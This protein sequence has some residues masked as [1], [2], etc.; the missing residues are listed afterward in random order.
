VNRL[1]CLIGLD[2]TDHIK[3]GC[4]TSSFD[5]LLKSIREQMECHIVE[6]RLVR[7]WPFANRRTRGNGALGAIIEISE[8]SSEKIEQ[9]CKEWFSNLLVQISN[10]PHSEVPASPCL[11][12]SFMPVPRDWYW[13]AVRK[14][15]DSDALLDEA[16]QNGVIVISS[17]STF[18]VVGACAA[19]SW[20]NISNSTWE[21]ISWRNDSRVGTPRQVSS[22]SVSELENKFPETFLNRDPTKGKSMIAP[23]TPCPV[24]YGIRG[25]SYSGVQKAHDWLQSRTDVEECHSFAIHRTNQLSDDHIE[26]TLTGAVVSF[27]KEIRGGHAN[28]SVFSGGN[29]VELVAFSEGGPVNKLLRSLIPGDRITWAGLISPDGST[30]LERIKLDL[31]TARI[32]GRPICCSR[33]MRSSGRGQGIRCLSCGRTESK[34]W[35]STAFESTTETPV[36]EWLE[37]S[38]SNRRHLSRPLSHGVPGTN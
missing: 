27:P 22:E 20:D 35:Y 32:V 1:K 23:R 28:I 15:V 19:I 6:R 31:A 24:L 18:G 5:H 2:D 33:T 34:S 13:D 38:P 16:I 21:L 12:I 8:N 30:H 7:L 26:S 14:H 17:D 3:V 4:T 25:S 9:I 10:Y 11:V 37:P 36:G 29:S